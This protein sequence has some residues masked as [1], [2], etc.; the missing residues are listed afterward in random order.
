MIRKAASRINIFIHS[1][2][3]GRWPK[4]IINRYTLEVALAEKV[5][6]LNDITPRV[7]L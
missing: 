6:V 4:V 2:I 3:G 7:H 5:S 1:E